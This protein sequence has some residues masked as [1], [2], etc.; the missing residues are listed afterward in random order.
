MVEWYTK[1]KKCCC[2]ANINKVIEGDKENLINPRGVHDMAMP[3]MSSKM[4][5]HVYDVAK[6]LHVV[7]FGD[8]VDR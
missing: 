3:C 7:V 5:Y 1:P 2:S 8:L 6:G 4:F